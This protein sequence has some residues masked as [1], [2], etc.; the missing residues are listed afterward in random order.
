V[1]ARLVN[2]TVIILRSERSYG[3]R[4]K[5]ACII[6]II[7]TIQQI[8]LARRTTLETAFVP[9]PH[10]TT[11]CPDASGAE[12]DDPGPATGSYPAI[13]ARCWNRVRE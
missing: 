5:I 2:S 4:Q 7:R 8:L 9:L 12:Q 6:I 3:V 13:V 10:G 11:H 1:D